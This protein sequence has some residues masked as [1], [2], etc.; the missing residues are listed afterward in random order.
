MTDRDA[1]E[2][3]VLDDWNWNFDWD[4]EPV[5]FGDAADEYDFGWSAGGVNSTW[6]DQRNQS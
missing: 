4:S 3:A 5:S 1:A 6:F 2:A